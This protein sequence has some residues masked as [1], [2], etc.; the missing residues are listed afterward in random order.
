M[1]SDQTGWTLSS[2]W[3]LLDAARSLERDEALVLEKDAVTIDEKM[4]WDH[5]TIFGDRPMDWYSA[6]RTRWVA[7]QLRAQYNQQAI[8]GAFQSSR[9][10]QVPT[11]Q[12]AQTGPYARLV[13]DVIRA[14]PRSVFVRGYT[15]SRG[16]YHGASFYRAAAHARPLGSYHNMW[17]TTSLSTSSNFY[18]FR[19][20]GRSNARSFING[21]FNRSSVYVPGFYRHALGGHRVTG[22][23]DFEGLRARAIAT[24]AA[25]H[26][27]SV[28]RETLGWQAEGRGTTQTTIQPRIK[29][30]APGVVYFRALIPGTYSDRGWGTYTREYYRP[31]IPRVYRDVNWHLQTH[32]IAHITPF[33]TP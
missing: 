9:V 1:A 20:S 16:R 17:V 6:W 30:A 27:P 26:G 31:P 18:I 14:R 15:D 3:E 32:P 13:N 11:R 29:A 33:T 28:A 4:R 22:N 8:T 21:Y 23:I 5:R 19:T 10:L 24:V 25:Y 2:T 12:F 7:P